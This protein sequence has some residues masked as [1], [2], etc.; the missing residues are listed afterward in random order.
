[1]ECPE[2]GNNLIYVITDENGSHYEC[3]DCGY[4]YCDESQKADDSEE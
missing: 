2:C 1:M 4:E 3:P